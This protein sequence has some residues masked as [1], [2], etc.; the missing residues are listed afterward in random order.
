M[1]ASLPLVGRGTLVD[2]GR[3][4][5]TAWWVVVLVAGVLVAM[6]AVIAFRRRRRRTVRRVRWSAALQEMWADYREVHERQGLLQRPW[7]EEFLHWSFDGRRW[8]LH[9]HLQPPPGRRRSTTSSGWCPGA[10]DARA[11]GAT[12]S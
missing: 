6:V 7:E 5:G 12:R 8:Q 2:A 1:S 9:G 3:V 11:R 4:A 10:R